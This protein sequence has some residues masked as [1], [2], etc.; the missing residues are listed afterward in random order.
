MGGTGVRIVQSTVAA[1]VVA[2]D[3]AATDFGSC[4]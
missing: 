3:G 2:P 1:L 4:P